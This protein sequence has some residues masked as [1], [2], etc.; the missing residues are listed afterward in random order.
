MSSFELKFYT[1]KYIFKSDKIYM[2]LKN[3]IEPGVAEAN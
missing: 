3:N 1:N 2:Y